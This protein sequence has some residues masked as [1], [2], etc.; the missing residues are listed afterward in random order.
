MT[1]EKLASYF[2]VDQVIAARARVGEPGAFKPIWGKNAV[3]A[4]SDVTPL[5][6]MGSPSFAYCYRLEGYPVSNPGWYDNKCDSWL[7]PTTT[8]D[9]P[10]DRRQGRGLPL[11][12][13]G[14]LSAPRP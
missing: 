4:Y 13:R 7:Y 12:D 6:S 2:N 14:R 3:L 11:P 9:T 8:Y 5:A 1:L 10:G